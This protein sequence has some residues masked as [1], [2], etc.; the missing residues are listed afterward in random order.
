MRTHNIPSRTLCISYSYPQKD[1]YWS[2]VI[3]GIRTGKIHF[4]WKQWI[5][6]CMYRHTSTT[7]TSIVSECEDL[8]SYSSIG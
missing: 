7:F 2:L 6:T 1:R 3:S 4:L 8:K 5:C